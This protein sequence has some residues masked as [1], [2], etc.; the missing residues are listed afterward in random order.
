MC[1]TITMVMPPPWMLAH[2]L[3][4]LAHLGRRQAGHRLVEQQR[5][6]LGGERAG[7]LESLAPGRAEAPGRRVGQRTEPDPLR[8]RRA[9]WRAPRGRWDGAAGRRWWRCRAPTSNSKVSGTWKLRASPSRA[10]A[11]GGRRVTSVP[12]KVTRA[13]R[14]RQVAGQAVEEGRLARAVGADQAEDVALLDRHRGVV[15]RLEG[16]ERLGDVPGLNQ[17]GRSPVWRRRDRAWRPAATAGARTA[18]AA[19]S[20][21]SAR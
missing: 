7:D 21:G 16:A 5:L 4:R 12:L 11:S 15:D 13:R 10:R 1:S 20:A 6:G 19:R 2:Q 8:A 17:H 18:T 9:P 14:H 3:D